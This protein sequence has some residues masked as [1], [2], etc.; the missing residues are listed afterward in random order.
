[1]SSGLVPFLGCLRTEV[2][3]RPQRQDP[4]L[5]AVGYL[6]LGSICGA[7]TAYMACYTEPL[8]AGAASAVHSARML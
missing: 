2:L 3:D 5:A 4:W 1:M 8:A 6:F 7:L